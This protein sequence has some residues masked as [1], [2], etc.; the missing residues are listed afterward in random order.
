M[1]SQVVNC[2]LLVLLS[3]EMEGS[4][5]LEVEGYFV[6]VVAFVD[7]KDANKVVAMVSCVVKRGPAIGGVCVCEEV[8]IPVD[9]AGD[10]R[11][12]VVDDCPAEAHCWVNHGDVLW[13]AADGGG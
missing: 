8:W 7:E 5:T 3:G 9:D 4:V 11:E 12:V 10:D 1:L 2:L 6:A 13:I